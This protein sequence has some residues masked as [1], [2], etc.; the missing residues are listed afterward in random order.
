MRRLEKFG[1]IPLSNFGI[2][3][4]GNDKVIYRCA[5][6][7]FQYQYDWLKRNLGIKTMVNLRSE[8]NVDQRFC[9]HLE[10]ASITYEVP[11][12]HAP[13]K[14]Q[15]YRFIDFIR[16]HD[17]PIIIHCEHG[18]G[19]TSTF[20]VLAKVAIGMTLD[21]A[22]KDEHERFHYEFRHHAQEEFLRSLDL[23]VETVEN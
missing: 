8:K 23:T 18:H 4:E 1:L 22:I 6:P 13:T 20:S 15:A 16:K 17:G 19:R 9:P 11:D 7:L 2:V 10:M 5:Q 3:H 21:E 12:H 14:E